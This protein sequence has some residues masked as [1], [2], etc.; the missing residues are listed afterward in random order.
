MAISQ[1]RRKIF[2]WFLDFEFEKQNLKTVRK[3]IPL[4]TSKNDTKIL[5]NDRKNLNYKRLH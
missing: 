4:L 2:R 3:K 5:K 1:C